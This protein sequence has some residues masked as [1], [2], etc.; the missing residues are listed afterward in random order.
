LGLKSRPKLRLPIASSARSYDYEIR[1][2]CLRAVQ[3]SSGE[4]AR[5]ELVPLAQSPSTAA[6]WR[7]VCL[8]YFNN[9]TEINDA[10]DFGDQ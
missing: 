8:Q 10:G 7:L 4:Q 6:E 1:T 2:A 5:D 9:E 3:R